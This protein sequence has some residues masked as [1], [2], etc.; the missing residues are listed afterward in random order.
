M[1][2]LSA[3]PQRSLKFMVMLLVSAAADF[4]FSLGRRGAQSSG[5]S[6][7]KASIIAHPPPKDNQTGVKE[8]IHVNHVVWHQVN[9]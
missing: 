2:S 7:E 4:S 5:R 3:S 6:R 8:T 1:E 9:E